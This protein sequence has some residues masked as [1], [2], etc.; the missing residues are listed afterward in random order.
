MHQGSG[1]TQIISYAAMTAR[2]T[3]Q[4]WLDCNRFTCQC[5]FGWIGTSKTH[6]VNQFETIHL[7]PTSVNQPLVHALQT[8]RRSSWTSDTHHHRQIW[9]SSENASITGFCSLPTN[10][11]MVWTEKHLERLPLNRQHPF[12]MHL[13]LGS[14]PTLCP[15]SLSVCE[16]SCFCTWN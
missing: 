16:V 5:I 12:A 8:R 3:L 4:Q 9:P 2:L 15:S 7:L 10:H 11:K 13:P 1:P 6:S 14:L